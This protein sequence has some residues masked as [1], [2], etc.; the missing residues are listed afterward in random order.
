MIAPGKRQTNSPYNVVYGLDPEATD[1]PR[2][3]TTV[4]R[5]INAMPQFCKFE[6]NLPYIEVEH[7]KMEINGKYSLLLL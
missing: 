2:F 3:D 6:L 5:K 1:L 7:P 4:V